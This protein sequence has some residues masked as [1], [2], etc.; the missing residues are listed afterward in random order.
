MVSI[1]KKIIN[2][3][4]PPF[5]IAE[6]GLNHNGKLYLAKKMIDSAKKA[7]A[8]AIKFQTFKAS[9]FLTTDSPHFKIIQKLELSDTEFSE[10][11]DY[12]KKRKII[13]GS[14]PFSVESVD[15]L[16]KLPVPFFKISSG[17]LTHIPLIKHIASQNTPIILST[18][19]GTIREIK[20]AI[21]SILSQNNKKI[22]IMHSVS[23]YP[24]PETES[25]LNTILTLQNKFKF[26]VGYSDNG[27]GL[28]VPLTAISLGA[29]IIE[30]HFTLDKKMKGYDHAFSADPKELEELV[31]QSKK[32]P[33]ILG[34]GKVGFQPSE[35]SGR[36]QFRRSIISNAVIP[37][38]TKISEDMV[39]IKRPAKGIEPKYFKKILGKKTKQTI[40]ANQSIKWNDLIK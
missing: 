16:A 40:P 9:D 24:T 25:N 27:A 3:N 30:K 17:D 1:S 11:F 2:K 35:F 33:K 22:I 14:T 38:G 12:C 31:K 32:L 19:M 15:F 20:N 21:N 28:L 10:L 7:G 8:D 34:N 26:P 23:S 39:S 4:S 37:K 13:F 6:A 36:I 29:K 18:G 5:I